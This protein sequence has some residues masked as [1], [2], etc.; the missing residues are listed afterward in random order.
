MN[1]KYKGEHHKEKI[2]DKFRSS[3]KNSKRGKLIIVL[4]KLTKAFKMC[5]SLFTKAYKENSN[6]QLKV[7]KI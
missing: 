1:Q 3:K 6:T 4:I 7:I 5:S 2:F